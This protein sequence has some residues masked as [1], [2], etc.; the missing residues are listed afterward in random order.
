MKI[1]S[2]A[3][4]ALLGI[5]TTAA[6]AVPITFASNFGSFSQTHLGA[7]TA[8]TDTFEFNL[9]QESAAAFG[10]FS[11]A[12]DL[13]GFA[14]DYDITS[15]T[16]SGPNGSFTFTDNSVSSGM[17]IFSFAPAA[18]LAIGSYLLSVVGAVAPNAGVG[19]YSGNLTVSAVPEPESYATMILG[20]AGIGWIL[21]RRRPAAT[22]SAPTL[23][24]H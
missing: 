11:F 13:G 10:V 4:G 22:V 20:L 9:G 12:T 3:L 6:G 7:G 19:S 16:L 14:N 2:L 8:Y 15:V 21:R 17:E 5:G 23:Y 1:T 18:P 24:A